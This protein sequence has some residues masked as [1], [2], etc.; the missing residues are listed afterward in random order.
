MMMMMMNSAELVVCPSGFPPPPPPS[1]PCIVMYTDHRCTAGT[2][3]SDAASGRLSGGGG[4]RHFG[5]SLVRTVPRRKHFP[6]GPCR[7][8]VLKVLRYLPVH[9]L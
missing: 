9:F 3:A 7:K 6:A 2:A 1:G 8:R 5:L 4:M